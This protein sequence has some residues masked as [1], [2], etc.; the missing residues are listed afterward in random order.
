MLLFTLNKLEKTFEHCSEPTTFGNTQIALVRMPHP[1]NEY[2][3]RYFEA[4][5]ISY[6]VRH[7]P[8]DY[9]SRFA[10]IYECELTNWEFGELQTFLDIIK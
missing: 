9:A 2:L 1:K 8:S 10:F 7:D 4:H 6:K 3:E 5:K